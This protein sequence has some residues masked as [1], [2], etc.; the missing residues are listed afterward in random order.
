MESYASWKKAF[1]FTGKGMVYLSI[2][3]LLLGWLINTPAGLL[4]KADRVWI[5][6]LPSN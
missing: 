1:L 3:I 5:C 4:G 2:A 6:R